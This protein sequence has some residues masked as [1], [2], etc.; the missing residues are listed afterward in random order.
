MEPL[1]RV[2]RNGPV[3]VPATAITLLDSKMRPSGRAGNRRKKPRGAVP[4]RL[5]RACGP[6][7]P[8]TARWLHSPPY[9]P[10]GSRWRHNGDCDC[11]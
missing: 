7:Q 11:L 10:A 4:L 2:C 9:V 6:V 3:P 1:Q 8:E 5:L